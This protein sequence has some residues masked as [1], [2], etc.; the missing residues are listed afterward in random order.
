MTPGTTS[1]PQA[2]AGATPAVQRE[3]L[4]LVDALPR[5]KQVE[6]LDFARFL[7]QQMA[8]VESDAALRAS[9]IE[10]RLVPASTLLDLTGLVA[11]GGDAVADTE[12]LYDDDGLH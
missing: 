12:A 10:L 4:R 11:L 9:R 1:L 5:S 7:H 8:G 2:P 3:L 6:I